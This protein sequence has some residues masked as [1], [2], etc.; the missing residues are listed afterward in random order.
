MVSESLG[1]SSKAVNQGL[2]NWLPTTHAG[3]LSAYLLQLAGADAAVG[4]DGVA[5][6]GVQ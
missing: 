5:S 3:Q 6:A 1:V 4:L 2:N